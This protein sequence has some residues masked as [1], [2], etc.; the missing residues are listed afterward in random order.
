MRYVAP[1]RARGHVALC[2]LGLLALLA[3]GTRAAQAELEP[4]PE[5]LLELPLEKLLDVPV[6]A[7]SKFVQN[8]PTRLLR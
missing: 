4:S 3:P 7:A 5:G 8:R 2:L 6:Y 1:T